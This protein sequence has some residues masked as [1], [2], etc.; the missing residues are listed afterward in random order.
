MDN[1]TLVH[2]AEKKVLQMTIHSHSRVIPL[3][4]N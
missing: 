1:F 2:V 4:A 3:I